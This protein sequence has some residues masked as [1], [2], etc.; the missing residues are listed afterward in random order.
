MSNKLYGNKVNPTAIYIRAEDGSY[1]RLGK[2]ETGRRYRTF[3]LTSYNWE[4]EE[5]R[6]PDTILKL[7]GEEDEV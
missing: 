5:I 1:R 7:L 4:E 2:T 3:K 6:L